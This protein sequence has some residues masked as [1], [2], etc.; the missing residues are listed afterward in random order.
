MTETKTY[1]V[2]TL[3]FKPNLINLEDETMMIPGSEIVIKEPLNPDPYQGIL[4]VPGFGHTVGKIGR[5][6]SELAEKISNDLGT[7]TAITVP[8]TR[9]EI[10]LSHFNVFQGAVDI[11]IDDALAIL[12]K[13]VHIIGFSR[14]SGPTITSALEIARW[15]KYEQHTNEKVGQI[16]S[17]TLCAPT[18]WKDIVEIMKSKNVFSVESDEKGE[19]AKLGRRGIKVSPLIAKPSISTGV[20]YKLK[21]PGETVKKLEELGI[22]TRVFISKHD[23]VVERR[24]SENFVKSIGGKLEIISPESSKNNLHDFDDPKLYEALVSAIKSAKISTPQKFTPRPQEDDR[25][26]KLK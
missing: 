26:P 6:F 25:L 22:Q 7:T 23:P 2:S 8:D 20:K 5:S 17:V 14:H 9:D 11:A 3:E 18:M 15:D 24:Y 16:L 4:L 19:V 10:E 21:K 1:E 12:N 13:P